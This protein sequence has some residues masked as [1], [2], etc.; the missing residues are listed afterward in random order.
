[1]LVGRQLGR[2]GENIEDEEKEDDGHDTKRG[3]DH[4]MVV[5]RVRDAKDHAVVDVAALPHVQVDAVAREEEASEEEAAEEHVVHATQLL[6]RTG[7]LVRRR[8]HDDRHD[9]HLEREARLQPEDEEPVLQL[10]HRHQPLLLAAH[11][12]E[13]GR[14]G[15]IDPDRAL[16]KAEI[17]GQPRQQRRAGLAQRV[18]S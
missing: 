3:A 14:P 6:G 12:V 9:E 4:R 16:V 7:H 2:Q 1:M 13:H 18:V 10:V 11:A 8:H 15:R 17:V 5:V